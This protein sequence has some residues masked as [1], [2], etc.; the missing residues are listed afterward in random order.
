MSDW[1]EEEGGFH[2]AVAVAGRKSIIMI[3]MAFMAELSL[4]LAS[5]IVVD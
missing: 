1:E 3:A 5:A 4:L 2:T